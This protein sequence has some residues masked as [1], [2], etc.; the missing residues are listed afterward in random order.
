MFIM[1]ILSN[2]IS[3]L[4][5]GEIFVNQSTGIVKKSLQSKD[6][7]IVLTQ[8]SSIGISSKLFDLQKDATLEQN[9]LGESLIQDV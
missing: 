9:L 3:H 7:V 1:H 6:T 5:K 2:L 8:P 4:Q